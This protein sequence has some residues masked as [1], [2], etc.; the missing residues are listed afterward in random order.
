MNISKVNAESI[1]RTSGIID[2][3]KD[4]QHL[5]NQLKREQIG[6][7]LGKDALQKRRDDAREKRVV[8]MEN[9]R[10][11]KKTE[12]ETEKQAYRCGR[13]KS[14]IMWKV[15]MNIKVPKESIKRLI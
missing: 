1:L 14:R 6:C 9:L 15:T 7:A 13:S 12:Q 5:G 8:R 2:W 11:Q 10:R 4:F 3:E